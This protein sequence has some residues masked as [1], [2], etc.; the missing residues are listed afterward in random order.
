MVENQ[1]NEIRLT[2][3]LTFPVIST[4]NGLTTLALGGIQPRGHGGDKFPHHVGLF[5]ASRPPA[6]KNC[7][8]V[9][10]HV[11]RLSKSV[12]IIDASWTRRQ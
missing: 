11:A 10:L 5:T 12:L 9:Q 1:K 2:T 3:F 6:T 8:E 4:R 7:V